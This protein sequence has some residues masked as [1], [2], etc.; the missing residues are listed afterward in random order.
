MCQLDK[1]GM[2]YALIDY[3]NIFNFDTRDP[4][5]LE[6]PFICVGDNYRH[7]SVNQCVFKQGRLINVVLEN[8]ILCYDV[9]NPGECIL[10]IEHFC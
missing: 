1:I 5:T 7:F 8:E 10:T 4:R 6:V 2:N 9:R 3:K